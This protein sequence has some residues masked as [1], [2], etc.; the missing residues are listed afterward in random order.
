MLL[1]VSPR[2]LPKVWRSYLKERCKQRQNLKKESSR[3]EVLF[4]EKSIDKDTYE[5]L[6]TLLEV[7][8]EQKRQATCLKYRFI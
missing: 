7:V 2:K 1:D 3:L 6:K 5:R 8:Y 4:K